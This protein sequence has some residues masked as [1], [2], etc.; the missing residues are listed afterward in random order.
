MARKATIYH[1]PKC[2]TSRQVLE[3]I[4]AAGYKPDVIEYLKAGW[5]KKQ[6]K[7]LFAAASVTP[8]QALR[9]KAPEAE[10]LLDE[11]V[12]DAKILDAMVAHPILVNRPFV[13]TLRARAS[14]AQRKRCTKSSSAPPGFGS[15]NPS[16]PECAQDAGNA[17]RRDN[18]SEP[19]DSSR[20]FS[21]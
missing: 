10:A 14:R 5:T 19:C 15:A 12:T 20:R 7:D 2:S 13:V 9:T 17:G 11:D 1:N 4:E 3:M 6:L 18:R 21:R 8:R 16:G